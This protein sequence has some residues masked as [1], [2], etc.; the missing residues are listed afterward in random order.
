MERHA[1]ARRTSPP[2]PLSVERRG[3]ASFAAVVDKCNIE[4]ETKN[5]TKAN[6]RRMCVQPSLEEGVY[7]LWIDA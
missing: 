7:A 4:A 5:A 1:R 6:D 3:G 2:S